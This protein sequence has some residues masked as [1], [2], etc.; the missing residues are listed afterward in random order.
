MD[1]PKELTLG[2]IL[3]RVNLLQLLEVMSSMLSGC[4]TRAADLT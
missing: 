2:N 1:L 3:I 4:E